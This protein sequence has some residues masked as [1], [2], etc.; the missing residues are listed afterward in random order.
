MTDEEVK[1]WFL[2]ADREYE[3]KKKTGYHKDYVP[4]LEPF[5]RDAYRS[6]A[7]YNAMLETRDKQL[8]VPYQSRTPKQQVNITSTTINMSDFPKDTKPFERNAYRGSGY[9]NTMRNKSKQEF[10][11]D[12][13]PSKGLEDSMHAVKVLEADDDQHQKK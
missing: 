8:D 1:Q 4:T 5:H 6:I 12:G 2:D 7:A 9:S 11:A 3:E 10:D 13:K